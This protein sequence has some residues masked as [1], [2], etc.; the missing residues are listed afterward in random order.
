MQTHLSA[1]TVSIGKAYSPFL[2]AG[3]G[4]SFTNLCPA[5]RQIEG[6]FFLGLLLL[7]C[8]QLKITFMSK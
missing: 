1:L 2:D 8:F 7:N 5:V 4:D 6:R 3:E